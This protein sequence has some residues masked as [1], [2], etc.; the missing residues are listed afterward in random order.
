L[1]LGGGFAEAAEQG[2]LQLDGDFFESCQI[3]VESGSFGSVGVIGGNFSPA[4]G[5]L[6]EIAAFFIR[7]T[8]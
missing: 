4:F 2:L 8:M 1:P 3:D 5:E 7:E 6:D